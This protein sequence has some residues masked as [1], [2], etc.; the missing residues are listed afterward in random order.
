N[1]AAAHLVHPKDLV[2]IISYAALDDRQAR[3]YRPSVVFVDEDNRISHIGSNP[4]HAPENS[5]LIDGTQVDKTSNSFA[6]A[7]R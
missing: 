6:S 2:I 5:G 1:G 4:A 3:E 7:E